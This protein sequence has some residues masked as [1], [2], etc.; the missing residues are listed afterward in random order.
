MEIDRYLTE[1]KQ[2]SVTSRFCVSLRLFERYV[3]LRGLEDESIWIFI[4]HMWDF[5]TATDKNLWEMQRGDLADFGLG[6][7]LPEELEEELATLGIDEDYFCIWIS[8]IVEIAWTSLL[9]A[10][11][12]E[13]SFQ[14]VSNQLELARQLGIEPP[15]L[16]VMQGSL[17]SD[18]DGWGKQ[19]DPATLENW[20]TS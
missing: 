6:D 9:Q 1:L 10:P 11:Q 20:K 7:E 15:Y 19:L 16:D 8:N 2:L 13:Q 4:E 18:N 14:L 12:D 3:R 17:I 5:P